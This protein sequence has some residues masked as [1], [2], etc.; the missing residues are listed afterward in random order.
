VQAKWLSELWRF[1]EL[2]YFLAWRDVKVRYKQ[3]VLGVAWAIIRPLLNMV[4]FTIIFGR[5]AQVPSDGIEYPL[6]AFSALVL[7]SYFAYVVER[8]AHSLVGNANLITKVYFPRVALPASTAL[9]GLMD[10]VIGLACLGALMLV[11]GVPPSRSLV[12]VPF[13]VLNLVLLATGIGFLIAALNARFRDVGHVVPFALQ[14]WLYASP[15]VYPISLVPERFRPLMALNP[16]TG[17]IE[18]FRASL[19]PGRQVDPTLTAISLA[20]TVLIFVLGLL[21]FRKTERVFA[22]II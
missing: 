16:M 21:Y 5:L 2:V 15:I 11:Y 19:F 7:W 13:F 20:V 9:A 12:F 17:I 1:R 4:V 14:M 22:D 8:S 10:F 18:G 3:A 6:F